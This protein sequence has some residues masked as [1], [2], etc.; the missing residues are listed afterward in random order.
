M[1]A[2]DHWVPLT[3]YCR[4][5]RMGSKRSALIAALGGLAHVAG[6]IIVMAAALLVGFAVV[7]GFSQLTNYVIGASFATV[8]VYLAVAGYRAPE[9]EGGRV[10]ISR[11]A[12]WM[13]LATASSPELTIFPIYLSATVLGSAEVV[14][15]ISAFTVGTVISV[16]LATLAGLRGLGMF[17]R[18]PGREKQIHYAMAL[19]MAALAV[20]VLAGG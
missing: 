2:P 3:V 17:L 8:A 14:A 18:A 12:K 11:G 20:F 9:T 13:V 7:S 10:D 16:V 19:V 1:L 5:N 6:S 4:A 15:S